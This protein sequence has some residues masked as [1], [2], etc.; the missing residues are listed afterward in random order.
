M[1]SPCKNLWGKQ[2]PGSRCV[3]AALQVLPGSSGLPRPRRRS[4]HL[5]HGPSIICA[6]GLESRGAF[7][8]LSR[9]RLLRALLSGGPESFRGSQQRPELLHFRVLGDEIRRFTQAL[10]SALSTGGRAGPVPAQPSIRLDRQEP[11]GPPGPSLPRRPTSSPPL[12]PAHVTFCLGYSPCHP[13]ASLAPSS[14]AGMT[15]AASFRCS[16]SNLPSQT[17]SPRGS[18]SDLSEK[19]HLMASTL[20]PAPSQAPYCPLAK[21]L[22]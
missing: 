5:P 22:P 11:R 12:G 6:H 15:T 18:H 3:Y 8:N 17:R 16:A 19:A 10:S 13:P 7:T 1:F 20:P 2:D 21:P 9:A 4:R 14:L